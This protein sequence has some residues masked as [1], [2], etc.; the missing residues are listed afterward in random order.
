MEI[1]SGC[2]SWL[3]TA[4]LPPPAAADCP[5]RPLATGALVGGADTRR[6]LLLENCLL[7]ERGEETGLENSYKLGRALKLNKNNCK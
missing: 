4:A 2:C 3:T 6:D 7:G 5:C 1:I